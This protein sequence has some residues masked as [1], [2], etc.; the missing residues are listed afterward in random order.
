M[1]TRKIADAPKPFWEKMYRVEI[2]QALGI[3]VVLGFF[4]I[5][6]GLKNFIVTRDEGNA[7]QSKIT[8][9]E[10][11]MDKIQTTLSTAMLAQ[12]TKLN[13]VRSE[14]KS[15]ITESNRLIL[16]QMREISD[17]TTTRMDRQYDDLKDRIKD[18]SIK[19]VR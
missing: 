2:L 11:G 4:F 1:A 5:N 10:A 14:L 19:R 13:A 8:S 7:I 12:E 15:D 9:I 6:A 3:I 17:K 18:A 16:T